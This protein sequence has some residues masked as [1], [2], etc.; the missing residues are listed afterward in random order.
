MPSILFIC[1]ANQFRSPI[2]SACLLKSIEPENAD[3]EWVIESAGTRTKA[4][5][6]LPKITL[7]VADQLRLEGLDRHLT[8]QIDQPL[9]NSFDLIIVM[10]AGQKEAIASEFPTI[11]TRLY[12]LAEIVDGISYDIPDPA[13]RGVDPHD[14]GRELQMLMTRGKGKILQLARSLSRPE[15]TYS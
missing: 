2:A 1:T 5:T 4:G 10:E 3:R 9:L 11:R 14:I 8:R 7:R 6:P 13:Q 12:L 15:S